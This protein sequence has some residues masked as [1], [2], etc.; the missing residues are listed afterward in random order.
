[1]TILV[2]LTLVVALV[3][4]LGAYLTTAAV[5]AGELRRVD[6]HRHAQ[7]PDEPGPPSRPH[8]EDDKPE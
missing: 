5:A 6:T 2:V 1:V 7:V 3:S 8:S 4:V